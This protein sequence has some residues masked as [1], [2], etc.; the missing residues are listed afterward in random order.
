MKARILTLLAVLLAACGTAS[1]RA[2]CPPDHR[3][4]VTEVG[5]RDDFDPGAPNLWGRA[6]RVRDG[7]LF[8]T[9]LTVHGPAVRRAR[10]G[11]DWDLSVGVGWVRETNHVLAFQVIGPRHQGG[12]H[13]EWE[14]GFD[15]GNKLWRVMVTTPERNHVLAEKRL[16]SIGYSPGGVTDFRLTH[17]DGTLSLYM[18][19]VIVDTWDVETL[20]PHQ[21]GGENATAGHGVML[22]LAAKRNAS[23]NTENVYFDW[24]EFRNA[25]R[26]R[27]KR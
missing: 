27:L 3:E 23:A 13:V 10:V 18:N 19:G 12:R 9:S 21:I 14:L 11:K 1:G 2:S 15:Y 8:V 4:T 6:A 16:A 5:F 25:E 24:V 22:F 26:E 7:K 20:L 17:I